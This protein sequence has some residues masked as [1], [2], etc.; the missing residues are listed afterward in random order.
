MEGAKSLEIIR[1]SRFSVKRNRRWIFDFGR[2]M[3][4]ALERN[5]RW[6]LGFG[7]V[8]LSAFLVLALRIEKQ[9][10]VVCPSWRADHLAFPVLYLERARGV[11]QVGQMAEL[12]VCEFHLSKG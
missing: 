8:G 7:R 12:L 9:T 10:G 2:V 4:G 3:D 6:I 5:R 11:A 1:T